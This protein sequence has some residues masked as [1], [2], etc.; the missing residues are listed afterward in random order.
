VFWHLN[1][2]SDSVEILCSSAALEDAKERLVLL[3]WRQPVMW[4]FNQRQKICPHNCLYLVLLIYRFI[5]LH[6]PAQNGPSSDS[7]I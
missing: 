3:N 6:V 7:L 2:G 4:W 5:P 1:N